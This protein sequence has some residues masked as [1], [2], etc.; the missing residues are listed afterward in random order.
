MCD[1]VCISCT[2]NAVPNQ[3]YCICSVIPMMTTATPMIEETTPL[4]KEWPPVELYVIE[5]YGP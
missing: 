5:L 1:Q 3:L 4:L 2:V